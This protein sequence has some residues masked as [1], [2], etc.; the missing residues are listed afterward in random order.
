MQHEPTHSPAHHEIKEGN[1]SLT[2]STQISNQSENPEKELLDRFRE[3]R[4]NTLIQVYFYGVITV[5]ALSVAIFLMMY[6]A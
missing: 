2:T 5:F 1:D 6:L 3:S 4:Q